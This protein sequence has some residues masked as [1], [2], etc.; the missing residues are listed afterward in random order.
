MYGGENVEYT[1]KSSNIQVGPNFISEFAANPDSS[2]NWSEEAI[3]P[4]KKIE[5]SGWYQGKKMEVFMSNF[6]AVRTEGQLFTSNLAPILEHKHNYSQD[7]RT[8][9]PL[10]PHNRACLWKQKQLDA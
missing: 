2:F 10:G 7:Y 4:L 6:V 9:L 3:C 5:R 1:S 8:C